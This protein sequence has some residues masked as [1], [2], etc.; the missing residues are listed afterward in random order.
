LEGQ[1]GFLFFWVALD[2]LEVVEGDAGAYLDAPGGFKKP[3]S[4]RR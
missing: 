1:F 3:L 4:H 2:E